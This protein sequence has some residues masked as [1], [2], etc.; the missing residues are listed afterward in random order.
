MA[1]RV[2]LSIPNPTNGAV[3]I[4]FGTVANP[5]VTTTGTP[6]GTSAT[7]QEDTPAADGDYGSASL[8]VRRD[9]NVARTNADGDYTNPAVDIYGNNKTV[10]TPTDQS[11]A[12]VVPNAGAVATGSVIAKASAGNLYGFNVV[13][14]ASAGYVMIF[15]S[16]TVPAD[17]VVTP[18]RV[19][20]LAAT[21]GI[22]RSFDLPRRHLNGIVVVF[23][24]TGPFTKTL[25]ATAFIEVDA[26]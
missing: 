10:Q 5:I 12:A 4:P 24:T 22:D 14:G 15:D 26:V 3:D 2:S 8:W 23:S 18:K 19:I 16:A 1:Q 25:S 7:K 20:P 21:A 9:A 6:S 13:A 17:G 11:G